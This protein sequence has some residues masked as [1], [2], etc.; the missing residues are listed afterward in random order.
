MA[1]SLRRGE[2]GTRVPL[3]PQATLQPATFPMKKAL[4][5]SLM[6]VGVSSTSCLG[7]DNAYNSIKNWNAE[8]SDQDWL[9]EVVFLGFTIIPVYGIALFVDHVVLNTVNYWTGDNPVNDPGPFPGFTA[10]E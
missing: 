4:L 3:A 2:L 7:P 1:R 10:G 5:A 8:V 6:A 9:N